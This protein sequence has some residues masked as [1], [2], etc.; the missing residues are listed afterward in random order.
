M[1]VWPNHERSV[2]GGDGSSSPLLPARCRRTGAIWGKME[3]SLMRLAR[4]RGGEVR[5]RCRDAR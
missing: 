5:A 1:G 3:A 4:L 2:V